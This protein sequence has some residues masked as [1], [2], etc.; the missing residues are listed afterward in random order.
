M[1][2]RLSA[3]SSGQPAVVPAHVSLARLRLSEGGGRQAPMR[4]ALQRIPLRGRGGAIRRFFAIPS[5]KSG[6]ARKAKG[7]RPVAQAGVR[8]IVVGQRSAV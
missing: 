4:S 5:G 3:I 6:A 1:P 7:R 2:N 8:D